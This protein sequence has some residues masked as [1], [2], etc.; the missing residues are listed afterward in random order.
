MI[1][2]KPS[3]KAY[4][5]LPTMFASGTRHSHKRKEEGMEAIG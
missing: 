5:P 1:H 3:P 2:G 4:H